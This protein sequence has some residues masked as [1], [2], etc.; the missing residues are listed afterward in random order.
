[1][2][3]FKNHWW[4]VLYGAVL[5]AFTVYIALDTF[6]IERVLVDVPPDASFRPSSSVNDESSAEQSDSEYSD[7]SDTESSESIPEEPPKPM[8]PILTENSYMDDNVSI[9]ITQQRFKETECYIA[10]VKLSSAEYLKTAFAKGKFGKNIA[11]YTSVI[12]NS[13]NAIFAVNGDYYGIREKGYVIRNGVLYQD[14]AYNNQEDLVVY[15][16]GSFKIIKEKEVTAEQLYNEGAWQV[17]CFG[18]ALVEGGEA[19]VKAGDEVYAHSA[20]NPR[21][22]IGIIDELH[23]VFIVSDGRTKESAG[24]SLL[25]LA[26]LMLDLGVTTG[27]NLDGGGSATMVFNGRIINKPTSGG[28]VI[29]ERRISDIVYI[30]R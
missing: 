8:E 11:Q 13:V 17:F 21:T 5:T 28:N 12:A 22:A 19:S 10:D 23:Y 9:Q 26:E 27:Y 15:P 2:N 14:K 3:F 30:D 1:M 18:P 24:L 20:S 25:Q 4:S 6:V 29:A 16:D 7:S